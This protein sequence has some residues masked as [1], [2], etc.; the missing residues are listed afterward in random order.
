MCYLSLLP[1]NLA[2]PDIAL[3]ETDGAPQLS[4]VLLFT[5]VVSRG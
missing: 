3:H 1:H 5:P 4:L 2:L